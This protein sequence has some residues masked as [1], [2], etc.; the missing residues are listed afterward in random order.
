VA[1][2]AG[3]AVFGAHVFSTVRRGAPAT[4]TSAALDFQ[5]LHRLSAVLCLV[6]A[7]VIGLALLVAP[8]STLMLHAA[9]AY[10]VLGLLGFLAQVVVALEDRCLTTDAAPTAGRARQALV[11]AGWNVAVPALAAGMFLE[12]APLVALGA[13]AL[14]AATATTL[15]E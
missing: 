8:P 3:F 15:V 14:F 4:P 9:S 12:S 7:I 13:W 5:M 6:A 11:F 2:V 1:I 10:G